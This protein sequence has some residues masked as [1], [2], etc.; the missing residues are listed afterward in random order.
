MNK[1][2]QEEKIQLDISI[3]YFMG[4]RI[5]N[6]FPDKDVVWRLN[7]HVELRTTMKF[8]TDWNAL[9]DVFNK[10]NDLKGHSCQIQDNVFQINTP[11]G[12]YTTRYEFK[13][14]KE[15]IYLTLGEFLKEYNHEQFK[16]IQAKL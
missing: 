6:S 10:V 16:A 7:N 2:T 1:I 8:S 14:L 15:E 9:M 13:S 12:F 11:S 4:W 5:D 3:A